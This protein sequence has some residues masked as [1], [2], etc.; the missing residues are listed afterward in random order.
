[1]SSQRK[2]GM[3]V[4]MPSISYSR[5]ARRR[6]AIACVAIL[7][8]GDQLRDQRIVVNRHLARRRE[9]AVV[10][11]ARTRRGARRCVMRP[12]DGRKPIVGILRV[13][14]ALDRVA[15]RREQRLRRR[16]SAR[17]PRAMRI[18]HSHEIDAGDHLGDRVLDLQPRVHL[19]EVEA[20]VRVE[21][22]LDRAGVGVA[23]APRDT[24]RRPS[25]ERSP[26]LGRDRRR[27]ALLDHLLVA[28]LDGA[29]A[30]DERQR[31]CRA[32]RRAAAPRCGAAAR[33]GARGTPAA[34]PNDDCAS[35]CARRAARPA[36]R[37]P[38]S[39]RRMPLPPP[40]AT[41]FSISG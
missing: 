12:G 21:Q 27:R 2:N 5:S 9:P 40:P 13:D 28:A 15:A 6:R 10:A 18:C 20:A 23:D 16:A 26:Q 19:E 11:D 30:L 7:A 38:P 35:R 39:T 3:V 34:S 31:R 36:A 29:L 25:V 22:E 41:A 24:A 32:D 14:A 8:P 37:R 4:L 17:S 33:A 1:M